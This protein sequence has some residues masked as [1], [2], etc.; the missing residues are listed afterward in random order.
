MEIRK[1]GELCDV[2]TGNLNKENENPFGKYDFYVRSVQKL[3]CD[4]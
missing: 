4:K 1:L 2:T 3:K